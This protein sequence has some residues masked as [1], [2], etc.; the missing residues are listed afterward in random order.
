MDRVVAWDRSAMVCET[1]STTRKKRKLV[2]ALDERAQGAYQALEDCRRGG[3]A[4]RRKFL[5]M[6]AD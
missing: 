2:K 3:N 5:A 4:P 1:T 6:A